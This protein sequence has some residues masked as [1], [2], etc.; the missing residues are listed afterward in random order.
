MW[1]TTSVAWLLV[2]GLGCTPAAEGKGGDSSPAGTGATTSS[3]SGT[4]AHTGDDPG[5]SPA[6][7]DALEDALWAEYVATKPSD[8]VRSEEERREVQTVTVDGVT[9]K[10]SVVR[11]G[12]DTT[13]VPLYIALHG[14]GSAPASVND[15]QWSQMQTYYMASIP[16]GIYVAPRGIS[17]NWNLHF[18]DASFGLYDAI[19]DRLILQDNVDPD[20]VYILGFSA[21]GDGVYQ[22]APRLADRLAGANMSAGHPNGVSLVNVAQLPFLLQMGELDSSYDRNREAARYDGILDGYAAASPGLYTHDLF[23]HYGGSHNS[24]SD[25]DASGR[26]YP[27]IADPAA[28]L[29][30]GDRST[31]NADTNAVY[32]LDDHTRSPWPSTVIWDAGTAAGRGGRENHHYYLALPEGASRAGSATVQLDTS[33]NLLDVSTDLPAL[34]IRLNHHMVDFAQPVTVRVGS[35]ETVLTLRPSAALVGTT[36]QE[37][38]DPRYMFSAELSIVQEGGVVTVTDITPVD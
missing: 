5:L 3:H 25:R 23:L 30:S 32:W 20:R 35:E 19:I 33:A 14:G 6:A 24:W 34:S 16:S 38:H 17:D 29:A 36:F 13:P 4:T 37:L 10:Y 28:W 2:L 1:S 15:D 21:G 8:W 12:N 11:R 26:E 7:L 27:V 9:M 18:E 22:I 31:V